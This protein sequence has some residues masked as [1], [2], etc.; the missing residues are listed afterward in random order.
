MDRIP[1]S[2]PAIA[3]SSLWALVTE[4]SSAPSDS[5][6]TGHW[7]LFSRH[8]PF[9]GRPLM[10]R[11]KLGSGRG[12]P[13]SGTKEKSGRGHPLSG[14]RDTWLA[15]FVPTPHAPRP[16]G[17]ERNG[18]PKFLHPENVGGAFRSPSV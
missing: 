18:P 2:C 1:C 11:A 15:P 16:S 8:S 14:T 3:R 7:P 9:Q 6:A 13:L 5:L 12:H 17:S 10:P 4:I